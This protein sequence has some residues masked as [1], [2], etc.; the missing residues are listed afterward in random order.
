MVSLFNQLTEYKLSSL[1]TVFPLGKEQLNLFKNAGRFT[2]KTVRS[3]NRLSS[4]AEDYANDY[5]ALSFYCESGRKPWWIPSTVAFKPSRI[6]YILFTDDYELF[7]QFISSVKT[8]KSRFS[9]LI[10]LIGRPEFFFQY[11]RFSAN[12]KFLKYFLSYLKPQGYY[13]LVEGWLLH[14]ST[15]KIEVKGVAFENWL[16][17]IA[18]NQPKL[19]NHIRA[20]ID[21]MLGSAASTRTEKLMLPRLLELHKY[22]LRHGPIKQTLV[23]ERKQAANIEPSNQSIAIDNS[24]LALLWPFFMNLFAV[25]NLTSNNN[26]KDD[27]SKQRAVVFLHYLVFNQLPEDESQ[28][29]FNKIICGLPT[30]TVVDLNSISFTDDEYS[31][32][33]SLKSAV[34]ENWQ[35]LKTSSAQALAD[36]FLL[37]NGSLS[38][39][40]SN[41]D[42]HVERKGYDVLLDR[43]PW[44][45]SII[46]L[47]WN[48]Y[49]IYVNW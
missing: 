4:Q 29:F 38:K 6:L 39:K 48:N 49:L 12:D 37:R 27:L 45:I 23:A 36:T 20:L 28:L 10:Q 22:L 11:N 9:R 17:T 47:P 40:E 1:N 46:K 33:V 34:L 8:D 18:D 25:L 26:F 30:E 5:E 35:A 31:E 32:A 21:S 3:R 7:V 14:L 42:L 44:G 15:T 43:L 19:S 2:K 16:L 13:H 41:W 24:G